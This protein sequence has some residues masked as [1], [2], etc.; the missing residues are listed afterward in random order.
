MHA[1]DPG[2]GPG[3]QRREKHVSD[4]VL[5][6][7][8]REGT[9][10][11]AVRKLRDAGRIP[12]VVYGHG[13]D[14]L[15][16]SIDGKEMT[17]LFRSV[18]I[19]NTI[20]D[21]K[22]E[23]GPKKPIKTLVREVQRHPFRDRILHLDFL[24][25]SMKTA[26]TV[27]V[28][29]VLEGTPI[30]VRNEGGI[31]QHQVREVTIS[32][33]PGDIPEKIEVNVDDLAIHDSIHVGDLEI[34]GVDVLSDDD[35]LVATVLPPTVMKEAEAEEVEEAAEAAEPEIVGTEKEDAGEPASDTGGGE[36]A[37]K[38]E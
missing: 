35:V 37:G 6:A 15:S 11:S 14:P 7:Q 19:E 34:E 1:G 36:E 29:V 18:S 25:V 9:G 13:L 32:C 16:L 33:L 26:V 3:G 27:E 21:L 31:L 30:G 10:T 8:I 12:A 28:P 24:Q 17:D 38:D 5:N 4:I 23:G 20:I 2:S 22:V